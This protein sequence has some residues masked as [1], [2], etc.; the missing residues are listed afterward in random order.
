[1]AFSAYIRK[2]ASSLA[3]M[4]NRFIRVNRCYRSAIFIASNNLC[5]KPTLSPFVP[6]LHFSSAVGTKKPSS[7]ESLLRV[8]DSEIKCATETDDHDRVEEIPSSFPFKIE[9][10][11]GHQTVTLTR[12]YQGELV[13]VEVYMPDLVTGDKPEAV[14]DND[15]D[16]D[17]IE[18]PSRTSLPLV[19]TVSK[20]S[21]TSLEFSCV[22]YPDEI[23]IDSL[24][25]RK[26]EK[27]EDD[28][29][30]EG[31]EFHDLDEKLKKAFHKYLEIRGIKPSSI[32]FLFEYM[33]NKDSREYLNWLNNLKNFIE[34]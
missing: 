3:P 16:D 2:S 11:R 10:N 12:E 1:M 25:V 31:P 21:G 15:D 13:K 5:Q 4:A 23:A 8:I 6:Q 19:V 17:D 14:H 20:S 30:Y 7:D 27:S 22:A 34:A 33:I 18:K 29:A 24:A 26:S 28:V 9:D 32:N